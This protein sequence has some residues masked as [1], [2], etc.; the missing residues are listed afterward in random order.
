MNLEFLSLDLPTQVDVLQSLLKQGFPESN[1]LELFSSSMLDWK[2]V[3]STG[4]RHSFVGYVDNLPVSFYGVLPR[5]YT[6]EGAT[7]VVG[8]VVDVLSIP[9][10]RGK[11]LFVSSG[12]AVM[13]QL[14]ESKISCVIGFPIRPEVLPG[15]LK[16]GWHVRFIM[17]VYVYPIGARKVSGWQQKIIKT[18]FRVFY[19]SLSPLRFAGKVEAKKLSAIQF[20]NDPRVAKFIMD[21]PTDCN[22]SLQKNPEFLKWRL[23]RPDVTYSCFTLGETEV[24]AYAICRIMDFEG[25]QTLAILDIDGSSK[26]AVKRLM[27]CLIKYARDE[28]CDL[29]AFC[30]NKSNF[31]RLGL[32]KI[33]FLNSSKKFRVITRTIGDSKNDFTEKFSRLTWVDSDTI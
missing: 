13:K 17:P 9:E 21:Q 19:I 10:M 29:I 12:H 14:E 20:A 22:I 1:E 5:Q 32:R 31:K 33:G 28:K 2:F 3:K 7:Y 8:L 27:T 23:S 6:F 26:I 30:S 4:F 25:F 18:L 24:A 11:G 16:V 15:H